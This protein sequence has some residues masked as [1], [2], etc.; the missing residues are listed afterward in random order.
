MVEQTD[1]CLDF[2]IASE[3]K[4]CNMLGESLND[5]D[6]QQEQQQ[7]NNEGEQQNQ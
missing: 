6:Q 1:S 7:E 4:A 3:Q 2:F 5:L